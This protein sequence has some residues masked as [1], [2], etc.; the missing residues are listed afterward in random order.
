MLINSSFKRFIFFATF[1]LLLP[2]IQKQWLNLYL[3]NQDNF[4]FYSNLYYI[5]GLIFPIAAIYYSINKFT[6]YKFNQNTNSKNVIRGKSLFFIVLFVLITL[7]F[8][9]AKYLFINI[10]LFFEVFFNSSLLSE[11]NYFNI[12]YIFFIIFLLLIFRKTKIFLKKLMLAN[13]LVFSFLIWHSRINGLL[14]SEKLN[15]IHFLSFNNINY[16]N[17]IYLFSIELIYYIWSFLS[18]KEKLSDWAVS[19]PLMSDILSILKIA[20]FFLL[21]TI[22]YVLI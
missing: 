7:S 14:L 17:I 4:A 3:F 8:L 11:S 15:S 20:I 9:C 6:Y 1:V 21:I 13:F 18:Y 16:I 12:T 10:E 2:L 5:S 22:Y 19:F